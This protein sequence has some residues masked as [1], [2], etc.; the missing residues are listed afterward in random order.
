MQKGC[1]YISSGVYQINFFNPMGPNLV[2]RCGN[3]I[4]SNS[5]QC[6]RICDEF[7]DP[8]VPSGCSSRCPQVFCQNL[9]ERCGNQICSNSQQ[10]CRTCDEFGDPTVPSGCSTRCP[11]VFCQPVQPTTKRPNSGGGIN[12]GQTG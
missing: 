8:T 6:C 4:C 3:Q 9:G 5:Q 12:N 2:E 11:Q 7:G 1:F 10:C